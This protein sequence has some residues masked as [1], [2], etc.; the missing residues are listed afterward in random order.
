MVKPELDLV[1]GP[2]SE[3]GLAADRNG[4]EAKVQVYFTTPFC[5]K[6]FRSKPLRCG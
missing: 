2:S 1:W 5:C 6:R 3:I 4:Y